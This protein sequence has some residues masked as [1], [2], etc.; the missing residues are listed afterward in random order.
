MDFS[1]WSPSHTDLVL[2]IV[3]GFIGQ[4]AILFYCTASLKEHQDN[5]DES[6]LR[7]EQRMDRRSDEVRSEMA[8][9]QS[10]LSKLNQNHIDHLTHHQG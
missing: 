1:A 9:I 8:G 2:F 5:T 10:E 7:L 4:V 6:I 3:V